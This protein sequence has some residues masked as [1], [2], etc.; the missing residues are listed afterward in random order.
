MNIYN[1][2]LRKKIK[3][4]PINNEQVSMYVCGPTPYS[5]IHIGNARPIVFFDVV[6]RGLT[7]N[8]YNV[9]Y[10]T[11]ITDIDDKIINKAQEMNISEKELV[12][13]NV[14]KF[15]DIKNQLRVIEPAKVVT[16]TE[17]MDDIIKYIAKLIELGFAYEKNNSV[18]FR[19]TKVR[20]YGEVSNQVI[21]ELEAGARIDI[22]FEKEY[23]QDFTL[24]KE[25]TTGI[26]WDSPWSK[27]RPG[28][29]TECVVM[30]NNELGSRID[31]HGGGADLKFPHHENENAQSRACGNKLANNWMHVG[32]VNINNTKMSKSLK[33]EIYPAQI[34]D[35]YGPN[36][37]RLILL[38]TNYRQPINFTDEFMSSTQKLTKKVEEYLT[39]YQVDTYDLNDP[40]VKK[41]N[42]H[43][44]DDFNTPNVISDYIQM[45]KSSEVSEKSKGE[46]S[47]YVTKVLGLYQVEQSSEQIPESIKELI[48]QRNVAKSERDFGLADEIR[49]QIL[50]K[51]FEIT[52]TREG[53]QC[54][55][56]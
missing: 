37:L 47:A 30:I 5:D 29:H 26:Q 19:V 24:W 46:L 10:V 3:F 35:Q 28:W 23:E 27:G 21:S 25:T 41:L 55:K 14:K 40:Y 51:G 6:Y 11:N 49:N 20:E 8:G 45:M 52:D 39:Q 36:F 38:Q 15:Q 16:V 17:T 22:D 18:Y 32:M 12:D 50:E 44:L 9:K 7:A 4:E 56:I 1:N 34:L 13:I 54:K 43:I 33:N 48:E 2:K 31:I 42:D 53:T